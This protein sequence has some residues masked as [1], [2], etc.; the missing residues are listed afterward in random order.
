M[1]RPSGIGSIL[2]GFAPSTDV[3]TNFA[4]AIYS[5]SAQITVAISRKA[6]CKYMPDT[7]WLGF[8]LCA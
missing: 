4:D 8:G 1:A 6:N 3:E 2:G 7:S 5:T